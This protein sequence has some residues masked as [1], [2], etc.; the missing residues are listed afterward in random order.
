[1]TLPTTS[2]E[3]ERNVSKLPIIKNKFGSNMPEE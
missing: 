3:D 1:M 2:C